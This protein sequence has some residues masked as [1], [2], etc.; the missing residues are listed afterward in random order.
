MDAKSIDLA[1]I[2]EILWHKMRG[3]LAFYVPYFKTNELLLCPACLRPLDFDN[4]S[5]EHIIP[6]QALA[7]DPVEVRAAIP[8]SQRSGITLLCRKRLLVNGKWLHNNGCNSWKGKYYDGILRDMFRT[9]FKLNRYTERY[10]IGLF[11]AGY[12]AL[13]MKYGYQIAL[14]EAG[15]I[16]RQQFFLPNRLLKELPLGSQMVLKG[17]APTHY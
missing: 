14:S 10:T 4:F 15:R 9:D 1:G 11:S 5:L 17:E 7:D 13:F 3:D 12:L 8:T 6:Q 16:M 2:K